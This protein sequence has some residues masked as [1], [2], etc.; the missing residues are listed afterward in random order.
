MT[1]IKVIKSNI[2]KHS[3][4]RFSLNYIVCPSCQ[5]ILDLSHIRKRCPNPNCSIQFWGMHK[6]FWKDDNE[7][8]KIIKESSLE[9]E[10]REFMLITVAIKNNIGTYISHFIEC[11]W[12]AH[13]NTLFKEFIKPYLDDLEPLKMVLSSSIIDENNKN[14]VIS[15]N[16]YKIY[17][18]L[19]KYLLQVESIK[20]KKFLK[21]EFPEL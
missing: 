6:Y 18:D 4:P 5:N 21:Q 2:K 14:V 9:P 10:C 17:K 3:A 20:I 19:Y 16:G 11:N 7:L 13:C 15:K 12:G 1:K 8:H